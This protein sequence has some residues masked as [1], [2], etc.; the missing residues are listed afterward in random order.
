MPMRR[1]IGT[2]VTSKNTKNTSRSRLTNTPSRPVSSTSI[3]TM[4]IFTFLRIDADARIEIGNSSAVST[5][6]SSEI[7]STPTF[8]EI[9]HGSNHETCWLN[10][11]PASPV[12]NSHST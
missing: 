10:W 8:H 6:S 12:S 9:P 5:T 2:S 7:P 11:N 1:Y 4:Y 3:A